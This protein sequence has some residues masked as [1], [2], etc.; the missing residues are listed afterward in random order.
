M[1]G[2]FILMSDLSL[3]CSVCCKNHQYIETLYQSMAYKKHIHR[4]ACYVI[5]HSMAQ[6]NI[7]CTSFSFENVE[8]VQLLRLPHF[9]EYVSFLSELNNYYLLLLLLVLILVVEKFVSVVEPVGYFDD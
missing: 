2:F 4:V 6:G 1:T 7:L 8:K 9:F 3:N 5:E